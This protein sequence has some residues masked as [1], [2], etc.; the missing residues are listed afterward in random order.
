MKMIGFVLF[1]CIVIGSTV[2]AQTAATFQAGGVRY[3]VDLF[4]EANYPVALAFA[5]DGRLFYTEK[6][7]GNLRVVSADGVVQ[8]DPVITLASSALA[9]RGMLGVALD[10]AYS[11]N[12][13]IWVMHTAEGTA[14][15]YPANNIVRFTE[16]DGIGSDPEIM[17]SVPIVSGGLIHNGGNLHFDAEGLL[18]VTLGDYE[19]AAN[20][21]DLT[22]LP[23]KI[24]RFVV[25]D[26]GLAPAPENPF[27]GSSIYAYGLRNA[28][29][30]TFDTRSTYIFATENGLHCDDEI[31][32]ILRGLQYG[33][34]ADYE[35]GSTSPDSNPSK[36]VPPLL[37]FTPTQAP[38]GITIYDHDAA[39]EW[40]GKLFF[41]AWN[42]GYP[43]R[44]ITLNEARN[45]VA[46]VEDVPLPD[47]VQCR[48]DIEVSPAGALY[49][50]TV[51]EQGGAIY[52]ITPLG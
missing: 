2:S 6:N 31:N 36:F 47:G 50:S 11:D 39:P 34:G 23:G 37:S 33:A 8:P 1:S 27:E 22:T 48:I 13:L 49:F 16:R 21:Q 52:R 4:T 41:C 46:S 3:S 29:D 28:W 40:G 44:L 18:Y 35:C 19:D 25:T 12:G 9:E 43:L 10:P 38:T 7:T 42:D 14:R 30:F 24:H 32:L 45:Q 51:G 5:P 15:D 26:E 17:L 20:S